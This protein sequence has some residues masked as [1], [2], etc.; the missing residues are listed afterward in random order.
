MSIAVG[1]G[2]GPAVAID[3]SASATRCGI[4]ATPTV[5]VSRQIA[6]FRADFVQFRRGGRLGLACRWPPARR[7]VRCLRAR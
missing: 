3:I 6:S 7:L 2:S 5:A 1:R 4:D